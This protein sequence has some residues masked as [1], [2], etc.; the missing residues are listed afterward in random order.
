MDLSI[1][2]RNFLFHCKKKN[3]T[4]YFVILKI[5]PF[6]YTTKIKSKIYFRF[7]VPPTGGYSLS[8][9]ICQTFPSVYKY[10]VCSRGDSYPTSTVEDRALKIEKRT[11]RGLPRR[12]HTSLPPGPLPNVI[13]AW[14][15]PV[16]AM[17][18]LPKVIRVNRENAQ[19]NWKSARVVDVYIY[20]YI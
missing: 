4:R 5:V 8:S 10:K 12:F 20:I 16:F 6:S 7:F 13:L 11:P 9:K 18:P 15:N 2:E 3:C 19:V 17:A 14:T 1:V